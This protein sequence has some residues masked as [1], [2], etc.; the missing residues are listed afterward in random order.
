MVAVRGS[1]AALIAMQLSLS[2]CSTQQIARFEAKVGAARCTK[3]SGLIK[4]T[5][6]HQQCVAAY[7]A[8]AEQERADTS[9]GMIGALAVGRRFGPLSSRV[10][11]MR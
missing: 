9:A 11:R 4:G 7:S 3:D 6:A 1:L 2:R 10:A 5:V 8:A